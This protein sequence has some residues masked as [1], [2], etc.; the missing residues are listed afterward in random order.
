MH[1]SWRRCSPSDMTNP[2]DEAQQAERLNGL[3]AQL[4]RQVQA[5]AEIH[6]GLLQEF[7]EL[8]QR[9][10]ALEHRA[11]SDRSRTLPRLRW[12]E[13]LRIKPV[14]VGGLLLGLGLAMVLNQGLRHLLEARMATPTPAVKP[15][16]LT[17]QADERSWLEVRDLQGRGVYVG[18]LLGSRKFPLTG[19]LQ[20]LAGRPD[21]VRVQVGADPVRV[22][23]RVDQ[24]KWITFPATGAEAS[25]P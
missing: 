3:T 16:A 4:E 1:L 24:V 19:G 8:A 15:T 23:G 13:P 7:Q 2:P 14:W 9:L 10:E 20:V 22:L 6:A 12:P 18:E 5:D 21:L 17:L 25:N 11:E